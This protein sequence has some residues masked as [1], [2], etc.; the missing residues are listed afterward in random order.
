MSRCESPNPSIRRTA[1]NTAPSSARPSGNRPS[2][3]VETTCGPAKTVGAHVQ[4]SIFPLMARFYAIETNGRTCD[5]ACRTP[6]AFATCS[7]PPLALGSE[8]TL[9]FQQ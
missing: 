3:F 1:G 4:V 7:N 8:E 5:T 9:W 2:G 6:N